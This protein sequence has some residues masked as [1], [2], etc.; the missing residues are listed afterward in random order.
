MNAERQFLAKLD[1]ICGNQ[2][3]QPW[4]GEP[5]PVPVG[6]DRRRMEAEYARLHGLGWKLGDITG[7]L[8]ICDSIAAYTHHKLMKSGLIKRRYGGRPRK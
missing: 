2:L 1:A 7:H 6:D 4:N 3:V 8:G 5:L